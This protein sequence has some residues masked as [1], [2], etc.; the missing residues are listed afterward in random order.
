MG[1]IIFW[2][3]IRTA[4]LIPVLWIVVEF[5]WV[6]YKFWWI[7][8]ALSIYGVIFHPAILQYKIFKEENEEVITDTLCSTCKHFN[9]S[10]VLCMKYDEHPTPDYIPCGST[11]WEPREDYY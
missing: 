6:E 11:D 1:K 4:I 3:L 9:S 2:A 10:A 5:N 7:I 8:T